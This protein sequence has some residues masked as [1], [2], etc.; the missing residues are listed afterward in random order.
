MKIPPRAPRAI[1]ASLF[2]LA[3]PSLLFAETTPV[4]TMSFERAG[5][6]TFTD[7][8]SDVFLDASQP[9]DEFD[10]FDP[11]LGT[12]TEILFTI[13]V[14]AS[15]EL[16]VCADELSDEGELFS[17]RFEEGP[18]SSVQGSIIY[19]PSGENFGL[20][21]TSDFGG[22][23]SVGD[24]D[25]DPVD[26]TVNGFF[27]F[28]ESDREEFGGF[29]FGGNTVSAG[30]L[31]ANH[32][33]VNLSDFVG[34]GTVSGL[35]FNVIANLSNAGTLNNV[36]FAGIEAS[37]GFEPGDATIQYVY[38]P[39][40]GPADPTVLTAYEKSGSL[41]TLHFTGEPARTDWRIKGGTD[42]KT[43][44]FDHTGAASISE[45]CAGVYRATFDLPA[46]TEPRYFFRLE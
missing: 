37:V 13:E 18:G 20:S 2:L 9:L 31:L 21:V 30:S 45:P 6:G 34:T 3:G 29:A 39:G 17:V 27:Y 10:K 23:N 42:L 15:I 12:L 16:M 7:F 44:P 4:Q 36:P 8:F 32:P 24:E 33:D 40:V 14:S 43:F 1:Y 26:Y 35:S 19:A 28:E 11:A 5:D 25:L 38:T 41:H 22:I 46:L